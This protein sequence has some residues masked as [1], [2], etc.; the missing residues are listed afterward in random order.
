MLDKN[1]MQVL[2]QMFDESETRIMKNV[3]EKFAE[4]DKRFDDIDKRFEAIDKRFDEFEARITQNTAKQIA[5][6]EDRISQNMTRQI[7]E[8]EARIMHNA[9]VMMESVF[10][11]KFNL[12]AE[13]IQAINDKLDAM[14]PISRVEKIEA[15]VDL[16]KIAMKQM[17]AEI[18]ELRS[19]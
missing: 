11:P 19:G 9:R 5:E 2:R 14:A 10:D 16:L 6:A 1:D 4:R 13:G 15:D 18:C 17:N 7:A 3:D 8:S 12:L